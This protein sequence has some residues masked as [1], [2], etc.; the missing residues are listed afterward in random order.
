[1]PSKT[2]KVQPQEK[3]ITQDVEGFSGIIIPKLVWLQQGVSQDECG[4][5]VL[6]EDV[7]P[8]YLYQFDMIEEGNLVGI[9]T[10][11]LFAYPLRLDSVT[12]NAGSTQERSSAYK[13][14]LSRSNT[15]EIVI[16]F[17][18]GSHSVIIT[19][20][21]PSGSTTHSVSRS[22]L[23]VLPVFDKSFVDY[24]NELE[25]FLVERI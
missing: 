13:V 18:K 25:Q 24:Y 1:M 9:R 3:T 19:E 6:G 21:S 20:K 11:D 12:R 5:D 7:N 23:E 22:D 2:I 10:P 16:D 14:T 4:E 17:P 8:E 15:Q